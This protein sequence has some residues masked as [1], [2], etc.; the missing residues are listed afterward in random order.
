MPSR[1]IHTV[2]VPGAVKGWDKLLHAR[3]AACHLRT[4]SRRRSQYAEQGFPVGEVVSVYWKD[5]EKVLLDDAPT[6]KTFLPDGRAPKA[7][8]VFRN[9]ELAWSYRQIARGRR[10][11]FYT[12]AIA[13][14]HPRHVQRAMAAR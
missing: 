12:G 6:A 5:S 10:A 4:C 8:E 14:K 13:R 2:T 7:G 3:S 11:A 9:P 1:G